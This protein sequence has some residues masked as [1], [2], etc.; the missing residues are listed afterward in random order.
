MSDHCEEETEV[1]DTCCQESI[2]VES[3]DDNCCTDE[4]RR[5]SLSFDYFESTHY[6]FPV[7]IADYLLLTEFKFTPEISYDDESVLVCQITEPPPKPL[8][9]RLPVNCCWRL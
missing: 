3:A 1:E 6:E 7:W 2:P 5:L 8:G 9:E 4:I